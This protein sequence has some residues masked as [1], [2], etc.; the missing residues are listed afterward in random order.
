MKGKRSVF[1]A[2]GFL[3]FAV[4]VFPVKTGAQTAD[5]AG[6]PDFAV[7]DMSVRAE[8]G[9]GSYLYVTIANLGGGVTGQNYLSAVISGLEPIGLP[10]GFVLYLTGEKTDAGYVYAKGYKKEFIGPRVDGAGIKQL[11]PVITLDPGNYF[12]ETDR[13]NDV[14]T[15]TIPAAAASAA[16]VNDGKAIYESGKNLSVILTNAKKAK[17]AKAQTAAMK[18]YTEPLAKGAK[19]ST[20]EK[21]AINNF[22]VYGSSSTKT[23]TQAQRAAAV[24]AYM[25]GFNK[26][27]VAALDWQDV[28]TLLAIK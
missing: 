12:T 11:T 10:E 3:I 8:A 7:T 1:L 2:I 5:S 20:A 28:I 21:Y 24:K 6:L 22:I 19:I 4:T 14:Y 25:A 26:I 17:N 27:P 23:K 15:R 16:S 9:A 18:T 13:S